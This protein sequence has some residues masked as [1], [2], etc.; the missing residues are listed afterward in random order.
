MDIAAE[1]KKTKILHA[2]LAMNGI[3]EAFDFRNEEILL[4]LR[5]AQFMADEFTAGR[6][7]AAVQ[8]MIVAMLKEFYG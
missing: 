3:L 7:Q 2:L 8:P 1:I 4:F 6:D 5:C